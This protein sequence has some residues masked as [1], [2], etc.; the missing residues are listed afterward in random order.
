MTNEELKEK[1]ESDFDDVIEVG[2]FIDYDKDGFK[3]ILKSHIDFAIK[4]LKDT[5]KAL[6]YLGCSEVIKLYTTTK[7]NELQKQKEEL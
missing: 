4:K 1:I 5:E 3:A 6:I 7:I 2:A